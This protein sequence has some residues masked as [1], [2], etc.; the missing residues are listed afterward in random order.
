MSSGILIINKPVGMTSREAVDAVKRLVRPAKAGHAGTLD[1]LASGVLVVCAGPAT[2]LIEYV[3]RMSKSY[4][5]TFLLGRQ[6]E[7]EDI[8]GTVVEMPDPPVPDL[9]EIASAAKKLQGNIMQ[10]PPAF[11]AIKINGRRSYKMAR[12]GERVDLQPRSVAVH[13]IRVRTY[14]Y[15]KLV[16]EVDCGAGTYIRSLGRDLAE[17]L[18]TQAVMSALVRTAVGK[19]ALAEAQ[20]PNQLTRENIAG[21]LLPLIQAVDYLPRMTLSAEDIARVR[22]GQFISNRFV[23]GE[24]PELA[25]ID[26]NGNLIAILGQVDGK[27]L[28]PVKFLSLNS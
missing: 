19:F 26:D 24:A 9:E 21:V 11:S 23:G 28:K 5:G 12:N 8:E 10:R 25:A 27:F 1:P 14:E 17:S 13:R 16:L 7:T 6:S 4:V 15:P 2:R 22:N 18:G 3:Q 20:Q